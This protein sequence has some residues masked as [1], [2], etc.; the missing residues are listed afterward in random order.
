M[1]EKQ[2]E[3]ALTV[4]KKDEFCRWDVDNSYSEFYL[5]AFIPAEVAVRKGIDPN[6]F[7][8]NHFDGDLPWDDRYLETD[9]LVIPYNNYLGKYSTNEPTAYYSYESASKKLDMWRRNPCPHEYMRNNDN[10]NMLLEP[11]V[12]FKVVEI[13]V[14]KVEQYEHVIC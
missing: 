6:T 3:D 2:K 7:H 8:Y 12:E 1:T 4:I 11:E 13:K 10:F 9:M 5:A 14:K